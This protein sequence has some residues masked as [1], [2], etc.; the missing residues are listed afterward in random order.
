MKVCFDDHD[1][2]IEFQYGVRIPAVGNRVSDAT[3]CLIRDASTPSPGDGT[4]PVIAQGQVARY[5]RDTPNRD[6]GRKFALAKALESITHRWEYEVGFVGA[7][8][9]RRLFWEAY[10]NRKAARPGR[11]SEASEAPVAP[12]A[13]SLDCSTPNLS[14]GG[15]A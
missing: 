2:R 8:Y 13:G 11:V 3:R 10:L 6:K 7:K 9:R 5:Y 15:V 14:S 1:Y 12:V 4:F